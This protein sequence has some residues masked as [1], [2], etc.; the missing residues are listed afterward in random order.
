[1]QKISVPTQLENYI[2]SIEYNLLG[3]KQ[4]EINIDKINDE[5]VKINLV[6]DLADELEQDDWL[7]NIKLNF[8]AEFNWAPHL[9]EKSENIMPQHSFHSPALIATDEKHLTVLIPDLD[10][11]KNRADEV[12]WYLDLDAPNQ[13][14]TIGMSKYEV[15]D[16]VIYRRSSGASYP[17]GKVELGFY[18]MF[19]NDS[20]KIQNPF[21]EI[22]D[23]LWTNWGRKDYQKNRTLNKHL[24]AYIEHSY[25]WAFESWQSVWQEF[26]LNGKQVGS[27]VFIVDITQ[28]PNY[29]GVRHERE[30]RSVWNQAWFSSLRSGA[31]IARYAK[32]NN[33][34]TLEA[35][36]RLIKELALAAPMQDGLFPGVV[37]T[38]MEDFTIYGQVY[39]RSKGWETAFWGNS[40]RNPFTRD[41]K[42]SPYHIL[43]MSITAYEMLLW[44]EEVEADKRLLDYAQTYANKLLSL[45]DEKG[46][47]PAWIDTKTLEPMDVLQDSPESSM[48]ATF[49][50]KLYEITGQETYLRSALRAI[51]VVAL[52]IVPIGRWEDF[53][54]Y[55]SC[56]TYSNQTHVGKKFERNNMFKQNTLSIFWTAEALFKAYKITK[57]A[58]YLELGQRCLDE[59]LMKQASW[60]PPYIYVDTLGGFG[61]MNGDGEW[62]DARQALFA[63][64]ILQYGKEL[65]SQEYIERGLAAMRVSFAL[66]YCPENLEVKELWEKVWPFFNEKDYGFTME[67]YGHGGT[68]SPDG[69]GMGNFTIFDWGNGLA[70]AST[71]RIID[72]FGKDF[73]ENN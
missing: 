73:I 17:K 67:N 19:S 46:Y 22:L 10:I 55:W 56:S 53:E 72:R 28:S 18:L 69:D 1:M 43:D 30:A 33:D 11:L 68:S 31:G 62:N 66:M 71:L 14:F 61:V 49:L 39:S 54:T 26:E 36:A 27:P 70:S 23:F 42:Q 48:S 45:Q 21:R 12:P 58:E 9:T 59:L 29:E 44:H 4:A 64:L 65:N 41:I 47:Y 34:K 25:N 3:E 38:E 8:E 20:S 7:L 63:E 5:L 60:Q 24:D 52:D 35:K 2:E 40:N 13:T 37:S 6:F 50:M 15:P 57:Q 51:N 16:H 32:Q